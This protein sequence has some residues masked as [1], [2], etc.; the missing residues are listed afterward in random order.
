MFRESWIPLFFAGLGFL[1]AVS[2]G[3]LNGQTP[4][5]SVSQAGNVP[6]P[7]NLGQPRKP[8][9]WGSLRAWA[10]GAARVFTLTFLSLPTARTQNRVLNMKSL[11]QRQWGGSLPHILANIATS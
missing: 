4:P 10:W 5:T 8:D 3:G 6:E 7:L 11:F 2:T 1:M 9:D